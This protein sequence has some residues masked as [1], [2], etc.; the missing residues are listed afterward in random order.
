MKIETKD[1]LNY[2]KKYIWICGLYYNDIGNKP[3]R[4]VKPTFVY[5][6]KRKGRY[7]DH[8][9][10]L[11]MKKNGEH[12]RTIIKLKDNTTWSK[13][14]SCFDNEREC[15]DEYIKKTVECNEHLTRYIKTLQSTI[16][17]Y[18]KTAER[19]K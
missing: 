19:L 3:T 2:E 17:E 15:N 14:L 1:L 12:T 7:W 5:V 4:H 9:E 10:F 6:S 16:A 8:C 18:T 13:D 11:K